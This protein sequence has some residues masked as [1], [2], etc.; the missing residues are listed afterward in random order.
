MQAASWHVYALSTLMKRHKVSGYATS[1]QRTLFGTLRFLGV[2]NEA[3]GL[4]DFQ[5][6][7]ALSESTYVRYLEKPLQVLQGDISPEQLCEAV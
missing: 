2:L 7:R 3:Q 5:T 4:I 6:Q 1:L